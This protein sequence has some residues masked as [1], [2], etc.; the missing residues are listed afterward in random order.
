MDSR[1]FVGLRFSDALE[2]LRIS[3]RGILIGVVRGGDVLINPGNDYT[4]QSGDSLL[5][6]S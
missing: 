1:D 4:I 3:G 5:V 2:R 6:V